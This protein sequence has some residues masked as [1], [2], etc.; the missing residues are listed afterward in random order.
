MR[1]IVR[2]PQL[3]CNRIQQEITPLSIEALYQALEYLDNRGM[4]K[5]FRVEL[6]DPLGSNIHHETIYFLDVV[7][8]TVLCCLGFGQAKRIRESPKKIIWKLVGQKKVQLL[9]EIILDQRVDDVGQNSRRLGY[10]GQQIHFQV[11]SK[12]IR[13]PH[14]TRKCRQ[15]E[16]PQLD[17]CW[18]YNIAERKVVIAQKLWKVVQKNQKNSE[19]PLVEC[20]YG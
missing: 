5:V 18:R 6:H 17:A 3:V 2:V 11:G 19:G 16:I 20:P 1:V 10:L 14:R 13:Q 15:E 9:A 4:A 12:R 7:G 8:C